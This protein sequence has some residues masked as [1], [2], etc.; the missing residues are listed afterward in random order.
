VSGIYWRVLND[1]ERHY[2]AHRAHQSRD[3]RPP[4]HDPDE[5]IDITAAIKRRT[6]V[7]GLIYEYRRAA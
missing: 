6:T 2:N 3:Q 1:Y 4:L 7:A 5:P